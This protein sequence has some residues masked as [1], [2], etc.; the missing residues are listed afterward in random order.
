MYTG[1]PQENPGSTHLIQRAQN[2]FIEVEEF[3]SKFKQQYKTFDNI[4]F[5]L[6]SEYGYDLELKDDIF[7][8]FIL[9]VDENYTGIS[10]KEH[11]FNSSEN[12]YIYA[13]LIYELLFIDMVKTTLPKLMETMNITSSLELLTIEYT[14]LRTKLIDQINLQLITLS[15]ASQLQKIPNLETLKIKLLFMTEEILSGE[16]RDMYTNYFVPLINKQQDL[17]DSNV[18]IF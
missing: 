9:Y 3:V 4:G 14:E 10:V 5:D 16:F 13:T 2:Q 7:E 12:T 6:I 11:I 8:E 15:S 1:S 17:I 18:S